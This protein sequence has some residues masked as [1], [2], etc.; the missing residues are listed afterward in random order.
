[1]SSSHKYSTGGVFADSPWGPDLGDDDSSDD[2]GP[3]YEADDGSDVRGVYDDAASWD[4]ARMAISGHVGDRWARR[5]GR[6]RADI[7]EAWREG[8]PCEFPESAFE[9]ARLIEDEGVVLL[10]R[11]F[12]DGRAVTTVKYVDHRAEKYQ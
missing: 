11:E 8:T 2:T 7:I 3:K 5:T 6:D 1:M 4:G 12:E 9:H 10:G